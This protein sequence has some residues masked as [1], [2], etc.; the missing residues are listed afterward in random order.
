MKR[1]YGIFSAL[2]IA[3]VFALS[4]LTPPSIWSAGVR[5]STPAADPPPAT[6]G[7]VLQ[8]GLDLGLPGIALRV[9][10]GDEVIFD[11]VAGYS[12]LETQ[13]PLEMNERFRVASVTKPFT[14][15]LTLQLVDEG[16]LTLDD[17][18]TT[19]LDDPVVLRIPNIDQITIRQLLNHSSGA[20]NYFDDDSPFWQDAY[21]GEGADWSRIWTP[22]ELL[23][24]ADGA[25]HAPDFAPGEGSHYSNTGYIL[26]GLIVEK[27]SGQTYAERLHTH[28][29]E[30]L[31]MTETYFGAT[32]PVPGG[33]VTSYH[34][35]EG[36][37]VDASATNLSAFWSA[38]GMVS[39]TQD[40]ARF[41]NALF[42]GELLQ[43][44]TLA[45]MLT[46]VP[47]EYEGAEWGL[48]LI[49]IQTPDGVIVGHEGEG[50][51]AG[52]RMF[53]V[54]EADLTVILLANS[55][56]ADDL[57]GPIYADAIRVALETV[58][59]NA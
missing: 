13:T 53:R 30:P 2:T 34:L 29:L 11:S 3:A 10:H 26:L 24:Y 27:A 55:G 19:W 21:F 50:P 45:E 56:G 38:G 31:G 6:F 51:G 43:P 1:I 32:E 39:T 20:Y 44:A 41:A 15:V 36:Q 17:T 12:N 37:F 48:G 57:I 22:Q 33:T 14:A 9:E 47:S 58:A 46:F 42:V 52:A 5:A 25:K 16:V 40:L 49:R 28:I 8:A 23:S 54:P 35:I 18:V 4:M 7:E 59:S